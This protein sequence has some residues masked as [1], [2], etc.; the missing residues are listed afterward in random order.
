MT[1]ITLQRNVQFLYEE[2][3]ARMELRSLG[4]DGCARDDDNPWLIRASVDG[5]LD[6]I[7]ERSAYAGR[8]EEQ[9][10]VYEQLVLPAYQG[11]RFNRTRSVN[12]YLTHW[13]YPYQGKF[14]PQMVRAL[15]NILGAQPGSTALDP[16]VGCG[17]TALEAS[18]LGVH[19]IGVDLSPLCVFL[20]RV[21]TR[22][23]QAVDEIR[24]RV[25]ALL[26]QEELHP[27]ELDPAAEKDERLA[28]FLQVARMVTYSDFSR[29]SRDPRRYFRQNLRAM[30]QSVEAQA[31]AVREFGLRPGRVA[32]RVGDARDLGNAGVE[33]ESIDVIVTSP[34][35]SIALDYVKNDD[36][37]LSALRVD[38]KGLRQQMMGVRGRGSHQRMQCYNTD[39]QAAFAEVERVL[40]PGAAAAFVIGDATVD[41]REVTTTSTMAEWAA[42][43]GLTLERNIP[44]IVF[45]LYSV[46][47][48]ERILI[49]RKP[50]TDRLF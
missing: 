27:D 29:R 8:V 45:G 17:T 43:A 19:C 24:S 9:S 38:T 12:Q 21:K 44:K 7:R 15:L 33:P 16:F 35:Y 36:H 23:H 18:L 48:D 46:M 25:E 11:G 37:A 34:P 4:C 2:H 6:L 49:F 31:Q 13:I 5:N 14:H 50:W 10:T 28:E 26:S 22:S 3:L 40:K 32:A 20:T 39:M 1:R 41:G 30:L 42:A 47:R